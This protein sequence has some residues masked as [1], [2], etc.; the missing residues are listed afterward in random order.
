MYVLCNAFFF[1]SFPD[2]IKAVALTVGSH[3]LTT[4]DLVLPR[5]AS[6]PSFSHKEKEEVQ[7][8]EEHGKELAVRCY[9]ED[10][11]FLAKDKIAEWLGG[12][13]VHFRSFGDVDGAFNLFFG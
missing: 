11:G 10:D 13:Y 9:Q 6:N 3:E 8:P 7:D 4:N 1:F 5:F 2:V 12:Q